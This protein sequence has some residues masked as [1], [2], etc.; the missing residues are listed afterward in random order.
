MEGKL[1]RLFFLV[2]I[3]TL[4][5]AASSGVAQRK[6][7]AKAYLTSAKIDVIEGRPQE[8]IALLD[9]LFMNYGPV[10]EGLGLMGQIMVDFVSATP[11][12]HAKAPYVEKM[13]AYF[14]SLRMCC[15]NEK[16]DKKNLNYY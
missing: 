1:K 15:G 9:S 10:S 12:A 16:I 11:T 7:P 3:V 13:V 8:A 2:L 5:I 4:R 6:L 14:D